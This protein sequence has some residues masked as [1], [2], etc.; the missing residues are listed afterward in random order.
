MESSRNPVVFKSFASTSREIAQ[1]LAAVERVFHALLPNSILW[2][3]RVSVDLT[4]ATGITVDHGLGRT[5]QGYQVL[6]ARG[7]VPAFFDTAM[8]DKQITFTSTSVSTV[9]LWVF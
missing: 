3:V 2:G 9:D 6:R 8:T 4:N 1:V 7:G 5:P